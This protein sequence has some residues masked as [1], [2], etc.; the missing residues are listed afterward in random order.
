MRAHR[1]AHPCTELLD[2]L[3]VVV[4]ADIGGVDG[5]RPREALDAHVTVVVPDEDVSRLELARVAEDRERRGN[6]VEREESRHGVMVDLTARERAQL[7]R[8]RE[9]AV[10]VAIVERLDPEAVAC[11]HD[12]AASGIPDRDRKHPAQ[13]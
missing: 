7:G 9:L 4:G 5:R 3:R 1:V 11:E 10:D 13:A 2:E 12:T 6:R 8:K